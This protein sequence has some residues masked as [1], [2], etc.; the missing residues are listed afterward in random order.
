VILSYI[1]RSVLNFTVAYFGHT[2]GIRVEADIRQDLFRHMQELSFDFYDQNRTGKLMSRLTSDLFELTELAHHGPEDLLTSVLTIIGALTVMTTIRWELALIVALTI[3][4]FLAVVMT[5]RKSMS[6]A[7]KAAKEKTGYINQEIESSLSGFRTSKAFANEAVE[8]NRF[9]MPAE[10]VIIRAEFSRITYAVTVESVT[11]GTLTVD[12][13]LAAEGETVTVTATADGSHAFIDGSFTVD[14]VPIEGNTF[15]MPAHAVTV[16]ATFLPA[17]PIEESALSVSLGTTEARFYAR[18]DTAGLFLTVKVMDDEVMTNGTNFGYDDNVEI[19]IGRKT[20][21]ATWETGYTH[22]FLMGACGKVLVQRAINAN[23][24]GGVN[25]VNIAP[26]SNLYHSAKQVLFKNGRSGYIIEIYIGYD[27]L[28]LTP[29]EAIG[30]VCFAPS[31]RD[32]RA[33]GSSEWTST[34]S[35]DTFWMN[36][37][38]FAPILADGTIVAANA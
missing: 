4:V 33:D 25:D 10:E 34:S 17:T 12:K 32:T 1:L 30:N 19:L 27:L 22:R 26:G 11:G 18:Y 15:V 2:F 6:R 20:T 21:L 37:S 28:N 9:V 8:N 29:E 14:G 5:M 31:M 16:G 13:P 7:S 35:L 36:A 23:T 24:Y 3:P 38:T